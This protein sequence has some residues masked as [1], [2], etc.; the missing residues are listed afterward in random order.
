M[1]GLL[2]IASGLSVATGTV[3]PMT[4]DDDRLLRVE[5]SRWKYPGAKESHIHDAFGL[6]PTRYY[7]RINALLDDPEAHAAHTALVMRLR[8]LRDLRRTRRRTV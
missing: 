4:D 3:Q 8:R 7:Q 2:V 1:T 6:S 5:A